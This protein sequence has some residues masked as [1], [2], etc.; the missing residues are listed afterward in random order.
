MAFHSLRRQVRLID[1]GLGARM[2]KQTPKRLSKVGISARSPTIPLDL[3]PIS[4]PRLSK[5]GTDCF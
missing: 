5:V 4:L 3:H 2:T 1:M